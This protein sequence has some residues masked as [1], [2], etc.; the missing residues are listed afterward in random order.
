MKGIGA[1]PGIVIGKALI[2]RDP[3]IEIHK[4]AIQNVEIELKRLKDA[5]EKSKKDIEKLY[6]HTLKEIGEKEAQIFEAHKMLIEDPEYFGSIENSIKDNKVNAEWALKEI[7]DNFI[8]IFE[9]MDNEYM[10]ERAVDIKDV[11]SRVIKALM[12]VKSTDLS[13]LNEEVIIVAEDL[14]PSDTA[15]MDKGK[16]LGFITEIGGRT[17]HSAIMARTLEVP[18]VVGLGLDTITKNI[19][20]SETIILDGEEGIVII[21]PTEDEMRNYKRKREQ[22][23]QFKKELTYLIGVKSI[24]KD[25]VEVELAANIG[26]PKDVDGVIRNDGQGVG[27][28][29]TE[30]LYMDR[31]RLPSE[32]EQYQAYKEVAERLEGKPVVIRTLDIGGDKEL[33][34]L[35]LPKEMNP[36]LGYRAIR[37]CL[38]RKDIFK[39]QLRALL[40]ASAYG[41]IKIMFPMISSIE[42]VREAKAVLNETKEELRNEETPFKE[43]IEVGIMV[44]IPAVAVMSDLFAREV[45]FFSIGTNDLLQYTTAIDRG[46]QQISYLYNQ[47]HPAL[48]RLIKQTIENGHK[49]GIWVGMCGEVAGD[50]KM[51]PL[52]I[53]M[54]LDEFSMSPISI[55]K[56]RW[57]IQ[58][59]SQKEMKVMVKKAINLPTAKDVEKFID[60]MIK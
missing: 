41:N 43:E 10:K 24:T 26:T 47:F 21:N 14:T 40:K 49:E 39:T 27:L 31:D 35:N 59:I 33:P 50:P 4:K 57:I 38:D 23:E 11:S 15:Q 42:E 55:L 54:G 45:D 34:Y 20:D 48:L 3:E 30:F 60:E 9:S 29:R 22:Y 5:R 17:S 8:S 46:N 56:A 2:K 58:N 19:N 6:E 13:A 51:I 16:V 36:F 12:G 44:E 37:L 32:E 53:G 25:G 52:L 28:Y 18:A 7:T 1:S